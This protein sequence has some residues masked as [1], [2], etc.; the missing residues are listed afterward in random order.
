M[1]KLLASI[2]KEV[3]IDV[4]VTFLGMTVTPENADVDGLDMTDGAAVI[5]SAF[6]T[7]EPPVLNRQRVP[8][9]SGGAILTYDEK[10]SI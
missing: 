5:A 10:V 4:M 1:G 8:E 6:V 2:K 3:V 7:A 9:P